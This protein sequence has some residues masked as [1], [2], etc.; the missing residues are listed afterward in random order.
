MAGLLGR[1]LQF[2]LLL[3]FEVVSPVR[4]RELIKVIGISSGDAFDNVS[5]VGLRGNALSFGTDKRR[6][7]DRTE[8]SGFRVS[9]EGLVLL[10]DSAGTDGIFDEVIVDLHFA[11]L[12]IDLHAWP[13][14]LSIAQCLPKWTFGEGAYVNF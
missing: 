7:D 1:A 12:Q 10:A 2:L 8:F 11:M 14:P 3:G 5:K 4:W 13:L 9:D 6:V